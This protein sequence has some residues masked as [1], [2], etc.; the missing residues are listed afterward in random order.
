MSKQIDPSNFR[1]KSSLLISTAVLCGYHIK[2][3]RGKKRTL[4]SPPPHTHKHS[5][6]KP[7]E[8]IKPDYDFLKITY[9]HKTSY[10]QQYLC[11]WKKNDN[12]KGVYRGWKA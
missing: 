7:R 6:L 10:I 1:K 4:H 12:H 2:K 8:N 11:H 3:Q 9:Q 5:T